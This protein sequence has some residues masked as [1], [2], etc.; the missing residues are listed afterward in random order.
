MNEDRKE[1][2]WIYKNW[3]YFVCSNC[4]FGID[5]YDS[6]TLLYPYCPMCGTKKKNYESK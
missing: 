3:C 6:K 4:G 1:G 2:E 5:K